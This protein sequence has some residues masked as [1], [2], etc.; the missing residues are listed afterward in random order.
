[1]TMTLTCPSHAN[2]IVTN[3]YHTFPRIWLFVITVISINSFLPYA[4]FVFVRIRIRSLIHVR[5]PQPG[6][7]ICGEIINGFGVTPNGRLSGG[8][9]ERMPFM[10]IT[11]WQ[12]ANQ[13][14]MSRKCL[15]YC[16]HISGPCLVFSVLFG[17]PVIAWW[18]RYL[19]YPTVSFWWILCAHFLALRVIPW[20]LPIWRTILLP[21]RRAY[22]QL[23]LRFLGVLVCDVKIPNFYMDIK[24]VAS[25]EELYS[26]KRGSI[27]RRMMRSIPRN[28]RRIDGLIIHTRSSNWINWEHFSVQ[29]QHVRRQHAS[30]Y[31]MYIM[32]LSIFCQSGTL[33]EF[34]VQDRLLAFGISSIKG[35][36][37]QIIM[38]AAVPKARQLGLWF[39]NVRLQLECAISCG[40]LHY[41]NA[42]MANH[43]AE[44]KH[45]CG[46]R[47][48]VDPK[49]NGPV[50]GG[51]LCARFR[52]APYK[53]SRIVLNKNK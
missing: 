4:L 12:T 44:A 46:F 16:L 34:R 14:R 18:Y 24:G 23:L 13:I 43:K 45:N 20:W 39:F 47:K 50:Y 48:T 22:T 41:V 51:T 28:V 30:L 15:E 26:T 33:T 29:Y 8:G 52:D 2:P 21:F 36:S 10:R 40:N 5:S 31:D 3:R 17:P 1:M 42:Y 11:V 37:Y 19:L 53:S 35:D 7:P 27:R 6:W 9:S 38:Y 49:V 25:L 32:L